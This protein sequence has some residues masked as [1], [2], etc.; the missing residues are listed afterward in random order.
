MCD[1]RRIRRSSFGWKGSA[2]RGALNVV[3]KAGCREGVHGVSYSLGI[4][5]NLPRPWPC[6]RVTVSVTPW[7]WPWPW[8]WLRDRDPVTVTVTVT[9]WPWPWSW[10]WPWYSAHLFTNIQ[11]WEFICVYTNVYVCYLCMYAPWHECVCM[12]YIHIYN[13]HL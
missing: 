11:S 13:T 12:C 10:P 4:Q 6:D 3:A 7:P 9:V 5:I 8:P 2:C 1:S